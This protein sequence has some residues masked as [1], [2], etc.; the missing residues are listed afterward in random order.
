MI[1]VYG[2]PDHTP[3]VLTREARASFRSGL[4]G[5][6]PARGLLPNKADVPS[7]NR[8]RDYHV[9][10]CVIIETFEYLKNW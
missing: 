3:V 10:L 6:S 5:K 9:T 4:P 1:E 8:P 7:R 2:R